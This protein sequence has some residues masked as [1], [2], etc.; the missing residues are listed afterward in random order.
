M[1]AVIIWATWVEQQNLKKYLAAE[2]QA[3]AI[4]SAH[5]HTAS[6]GWLQMFARMAAIFTGVTSRR[7]VFIRCAANMR[8]SG[9]NMPGWVMRAATWPSSKNYAPNLPTWRHMYRSNPLVVESVCPP[10]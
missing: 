4:T 1:L 3:G 5:F 10:L 6:S 2:V 9:D 7:P 8:T